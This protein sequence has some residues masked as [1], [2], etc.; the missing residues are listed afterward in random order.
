M[1]LVLD[2]SMAVSWLLKRKDAVELTLSR[3]ALDC[4]RQSGATVPALWYPEVA[5]ALLLAERQKVINAV[6]ISGYLSGLAYWKIAQD[7]AEPA[8]F[9]PRIIHLGRVHKLTAYDATYLELAMRRTAALA[10]FDRKLAEAARA[11]GVRVFGD[12]A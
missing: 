11:A 1:I 8:L 4:V 2:A 12:P 9:Q 10:T 5:N 6:E 7:P 3:Q